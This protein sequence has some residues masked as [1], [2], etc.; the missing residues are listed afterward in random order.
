MWKECDIAQIQKLS[1]NFLV[2][3]LEYHKKYLSDGSR[4]PGRE[5]NSEH[6]GN[7]VGSYLSDRNARYNDTMI[8][9]MSTVM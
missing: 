7:E 6:T 4:C 5:M 8:T 9:I 2:E 3:A 1:H